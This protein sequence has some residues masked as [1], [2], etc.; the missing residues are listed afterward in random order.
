MFK[1]GNSSKHGLF[2]V[3]EGCS[4]EF[5]IVENGCSLC[6][7]LFFVKSPLVHN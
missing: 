4:N 6:S 7:L 3:G 1:T 2:G 5:S